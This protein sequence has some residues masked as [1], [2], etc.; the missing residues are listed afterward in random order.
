MAHPASPTEAL[1][2]VVL[3]ASRW[4]ADLAQWPD[5]MPRGIA[6]V[7]LDG[8]S[9]PEAPSHEEQAVVPVSPAGSVGRFLVAATRSRVD[10]RRLWRLARDPDLAGLGAG[11]VV[12]AADAEADRLL[13]AAPMVPSAVRIVLSDEARLIGDALTALRRALEAVS[14]RNEHAG[15][16][17]PVDEADDDTLVAALRSAARETLRVTPAALV[18]TDSVAQHARSW[19]ADLPHLRAAR[20]VTEAL[21][22]LAWPAATAGASGLT[23]RLCWARWWTD[24]DPD[25]TD[26]RDAAARAVAGANAALAADSMDVAIGRWC[27]A[28]ELLYHREM[29]ADVEHSPLVDGPQEWL[30][31]LFASPV[32]EALV[33]RRPERRRQ[34][35]PHTDR[36]E[37][38][39][40]VV[41]GTSGEFHEEVATAV[42]SVAEVRIADVTDMFKRLRRQRRPTELALHDVAAMRSLGVGPPD[43]AAD[44]VARAQRLR[45]IVTPYDVVFSDWA[46]ASTVWLSVVC[47]SRVRLV[48]RIHSVDALDAWFPLVDWVNV[49]EVIVIA[50]TVQSLVVDLLAALGITS[51]RVTLLP[52]LVGVDALSPDKDEGARHT[53]GLIGWARRVKDMAWALDVLE[54]DPA[55]RLVLIG[56]PLTEPH[57][58]ARA[59]R[60]FEEVL[61]RM[62]QPHL[63]DRLDVVGWT[64]DVGSHLRRVGVMLSTSRREGNHHGLVEGAA[65]GAVPVVRDWPLFA[66]RGGARAVFPADWVVEDVE[67]AVT[68][69]R[70]TTADEA[71]WNR[72]RMAAREQA[73]SLFDPDA[74]AEQYRATV[75][76]VRADEDSGQRPST[77][78]T[79]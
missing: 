66:R 73:L 46:D 34:L 41:T 35:G 1:S 16:G 63:R 40:V 52:G 68:R 3:V 65:T 38:R 22:G 64:D 8:S 57:G 20:L 60:Y 59:R 43:E 61:N 71:T 44:Q 14:Q 53:L 72:V 4:S 51:L 58:G 62:D 79:S 50:P 69:I 10:P 12:V 6:L 24:P 67:Q 15:E 13:R 47:P 28:W 5:G 55:W 25:P 31:E 36:A 48:V 49:D 27:D 74:A 2:R 37:P 42:G 78:G 39:V 75:I 32:L 77:S 26:V 17:R 23:A 56:H 76:G 7:T 11:D 29:H 70:A 18:P 21:D 30:G 45:R 19:V 9:A 54:Q 33:R